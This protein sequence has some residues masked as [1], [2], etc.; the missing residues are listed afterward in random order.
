MAKRK[1]GVGKESAH[2]KEDGGM[3][4]DNRSGYSN[5]PTEV[6]HKNWS[7]RDAN[8]MPTMPDLYERVEQ[9]LKTDSS[10]FMRLMDPKKY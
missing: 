9:Q 8:Y 1:Y 6:I 4:H 7:T 5:L 3:L 10:D 2:M